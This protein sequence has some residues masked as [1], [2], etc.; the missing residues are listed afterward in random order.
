MTAA[1]LN[2]AK[3]PVRIPQLST[4]VTEDEGE[5][6]EES[7]EQVEVRSQNVGRI[8]SNLQAGADVASAVSL[9]SNQKLCCPG[10]KLH[11]MGFCL[12]EAEA[13][14]IETDVISLYVNGRDLLH[15]SR[16]AF[17]IDLLG[18]TENE[19]FEKYPRAYQWIYERVK[20]ER[21]QNNRESYRENWWIFGEPRASFR[22]VLKDLTR[23]IVTVETAKHRAFL[24]LDH[25]VIPDNRII[26]MALDDAYSL[27]ILSSEVHVKWALAA[28]G[29]MGVGNDPIYSKT[30]C[31]DKF[32]FPDST[33]EQKQ[34][35]RELGEKLD[36]HRKQVQA[37]N[38]DVTITGMYNLLEKLRAGEPFTDK[39]REYNDKALVS[40]LKQIH[41]KLD[42]AVLDAYG[43]HH[44]ISDEE[45]LE[46]LVA[47]NAERAEE[48][49]N[50]LIRWLRPEYQAP[51]EVGRQQVIAGVIEPEEVTVAP[52]AQ[53]TL[54]KKP[55]D[56]LAAIRDLL[57]STGG[58]WTVE[59]VAAQFNGAQRQK[60]A[61]FENLERL[62][63]FGIL[64]SR[65]EGGV[66]R[67]QFAQ[68]QQVA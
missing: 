22:P 48:E 37:Q 10:V 41:N 20:P 30:T 36:S 31:F 9:R 34:K 46:R 68:I 50:G 24:F 23:Y 38:P 42:M 16:N 57:L 67:W 29:R 21:D 49:R 44:D 45:I 17:V 7:A 39:D 55:K 66:T 12:T 56:Q 11:G 2:D 35:I 61:I 33:R 27:G 1:E 65:E 32:P 47:L 60:K 5:T 62:E 26:V 64:I 13:N 8:F 54:P 4:V 28:G 14:S 6:P 51:D 19:V 25:K 40:T 43:W 18:F 59:Q 3:K 63:W 58:E 53:K 15:T 52:A